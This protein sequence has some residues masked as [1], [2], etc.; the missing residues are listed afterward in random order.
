MQNDVLLTIEY[1]VFLIWLA[2]LKK[3]KKKCVCVPD[4]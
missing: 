3:E 2:A 1:I 4:L